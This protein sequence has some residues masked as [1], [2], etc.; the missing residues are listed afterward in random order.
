MTLPVKKL[1]F[2]NLLFLLLSFPALSDEYKIT[3]HENAMFWTIDSFDKNGNPSRIYVSGTIHLAD[4]S[5]YPVPDFILQAWDESDRIYGEISSDDWTDY[6]SIFMKHLSSSLITDGFNIEEVLSPEEI[7]TIKSI[8]GQENY[9]NFIQFEPWVITQTLSGLLYNESTLDSKYSYDV[10]YINKSFSEEITMFGLDT[11]EEQLSLLSYGNRESQI[12]MLKDSLE[13][14][15]SG[16]EDS[17]KELE[18]LYN[19]YKSYDE[20]I[21]ANHYYSQIQEEIERNEFYNEYYK[22]MLEVRNKKWAEKFSDLL[23]EGGTTFIFAG[24]AHF[25]GDKSVFKFL[26]EEKSF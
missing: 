1:F 15:K 21:F 24:C 9:L 17:L 18:N 6:Q 16:N 10:F 19:A 11:L 7:E 8:L 23:N 13:A 26:Q 22:Q 4:E 2:I 3:K 5:I 14:L 20:E 25:T 12:Q